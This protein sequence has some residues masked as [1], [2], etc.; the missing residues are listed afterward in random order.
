MLKCGHV[1][2]F[3]VAG[4]FSTKSYYGLSKSKVICDLNTMTLK[5][6]LALLCGIST[7]I[8]G[9]VRYKKECCAFASE[10]PVY[11]YMMPK[12]SNI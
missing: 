5:K 2:Q 4:L 11:C 7:S 9:Q 10:N 8:R 1:P 3:P 12:H 6:V